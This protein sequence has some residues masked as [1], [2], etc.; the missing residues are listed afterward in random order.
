MCL[1]CPFVL[2]LFLGSVLIRTKKCREG[3]STGYSILKFFVPSSGQLVYFMGF[4]KDRDAGRKVFN[5][6]KCDY[7]YHSK[8]AMAKIAKSARL[9]LFL[10]CIFMQYYY[11]QVMCNRTL[12]TKEAV[13]NAVCD[14]TVVLKSEIKSRTSHSVLSRARYGWAAL[15]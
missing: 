2:V 10:S 11:C 9:C 7:E 14:L 13:A 12:R 5:P 8:T 3:K 1:I 6:V 4:G 15:L